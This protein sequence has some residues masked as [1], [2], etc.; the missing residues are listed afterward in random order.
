MNEDFQN[1]VAYL[2]ASDDRL[3][4][5]TKEETRGCPRPGVAPGALQDALRR[6][7]DRGRSGWSTEEVRRDPKT[8]T[9][10]CIHIKGSLL[11]EPFSYLYVKE[12]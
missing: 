11:Y 12:P 1:F 7:G 5:A 8:R 6:R 10:H 3:Q 9:T 2:Q 4:Q